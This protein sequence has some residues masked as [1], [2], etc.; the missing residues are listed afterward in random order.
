LSTV[1]QPAASAIVQRVR[2]GDANWPKEVAWNELN[3]A[4]GGHLIKVAPLLSA[5]E[6]NPHSEA[7]A[8]ELQGLRNPEY[9]G[10]Q[11]SL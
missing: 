2:R 6:D 8:A 9:L 5:C 7:C 4:A 11:A 3:R 10:D 1:D